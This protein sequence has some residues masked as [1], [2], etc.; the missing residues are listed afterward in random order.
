QRVHTPA[1]AGG[2]EG[3]SVSPNYC[4]YRGLEPYTEEDRRFFFGRE[5]D[6]KIIG[7][8]LLAARLTVL[9]GGSG[10]GKT[11]VLRAGVIP[12]LQNAPHA[13]VVFFNTWQ[14]PEFETTL[15]TAIA[16]A[17]SQRAVSQVSLDSLKPLDEFVLECT[18]LLRG[19]IFLIFDQFEEYFLY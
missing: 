13:A 17:V 8:N 1:A 4:P 12:E 19:S 6:T 3:V 10:V 16:A 15:K 2:A 9:Y 7:A 14:Q 5:R 18:R 11:S